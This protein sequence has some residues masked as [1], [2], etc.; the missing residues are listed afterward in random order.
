MGRFVNLVV[1]TGA[2]PDVHL[3]NGIIVALQNLPLSHTESLRCLLDA[4]PPPTDY[5]VS[6]SCSRSQYVLH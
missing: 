3:A 1:N 5:E 4:T 2:F 6:G